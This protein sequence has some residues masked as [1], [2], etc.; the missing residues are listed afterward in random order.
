MNKIVSWWRTANKGWYRSEY[1]RLYSIMMYVLTG[2]LV[3][4]VGIAFFINNYTDVFLQY[5]GVFDALLSLM[6]L[7]TPALLGC[8]FIL[9]WVDSHERKIAKKRKQ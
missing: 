9:L 4:I 6:I 8:C 2:I 1:K 5:D 3:A 7:T